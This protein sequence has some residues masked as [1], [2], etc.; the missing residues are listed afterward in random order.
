[1]DH[2]GALLAIARGAGDVQAG[3][4]PLRWRRGHV[5]PPRRR[6]A[7]RDDAG[8]GPP[9][10]GR[11]RVARPQGG[12]GQA[13]DRAGGAGHDHGPDPAAHRLR[14]TACRGASGGRSR[15]LGMLAGA[16]RRLE[17]GDKAGGDGP[18]HLPGRARDAL[19]RQGPRPRRHHLLRP[20]GGHQLR[21]PGAEG[22][23]HRQGACRRRRLP[24]GARPRRDRRQDRRRLPRDRSRLHHPRPL[25]RPEHDHRHPPG[26]AEEARDAV[27]GDA[28]DLRCLTEANP[29]RS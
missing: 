1:M 2:Y 18:R 4:D 17:G 22:H 15:E 19:Q 11:P 7:G 16:L 24:P 9:R 25:H 29:R 21:P 13:A 8:S 23:R 20:R 6:S 12:A 27:D 28:R 10:P 5:L 3:P 14:E 26:D